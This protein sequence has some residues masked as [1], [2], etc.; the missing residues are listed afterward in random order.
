MNSRMRLAPWLMIVATVIG[1]GVASGA[2]GVDNWCNNPV[3]TPKPTPRPTPAPPCEPKECDKCKRSPCYVG[4]G[5][6]ETKADDLIVKTTGFPLQ[7]GRSYQ[8]SLAIDGP[9]GFGWSSS[10][11]VRIFYAVYLFAAPSTYQKEADIVM[12]DGAR[13]SFK[14]TG[15]GVFTPPMGRYDTLIR[16]ADQSFDMILQRSQSVLHFDPTGNL[17]SMTDDYGNVL[18]WV[19]DGNGRLQR[20][21]DAGGSGRYFDVFWG[22]DGRLSSVRDSSGRQI[23]YLYNASGALSSATDAASR[24][25]TYSYVQGRFSPLLSR[26]SDPWGRV[27]T[28]ITYD[29]GD[30]VRTYT[31]AGETYTYTYAYLGNSAVTAKTDSQGN[32]FIYPFNGVGLVS[33][34]TPPSGGGGPTHTDYYP[35]G[36]VQQFIDAVGVKS[37]NTYTANGSPLTVTKDYQGPSSVRYDYAYDPHFPAKPISI[38]PKKPTTGQVDPNWQAWRYDY[39]QAGD[40]APGALHHV[41]RV[42]DDGTTLDTMAT[43]EYDSQ[44]RITHQTGPTGGMTDYAYD[45]AGNL[46]TVTA[47]ANN[48]LGIRPVTTSGYDSLGRATSLTD[49]MSHS[50]TYAFDT[51]D[52]VISLTLPKPSAISSLTFTT[53]YAYDNYDSPSLLLFIH[54]TDPNAR[55]RKQGYDQYGQLVRSIDSQGN[56]TAYAHTRGVLTSMTDSNGNISNYAYDSGRRMTSTIF[57][58]N[59]IESYSYTGDNLL[60]QKTDRKN[61]TITYSYDHFKR[62][63]SKGY[64]NSTS[65][66]C[67]YQGQK[68]TQIVDT[69]VSPSETHT[70]TYDT[71]YRLESETQATRG[72]ISRQYNVDDTVASYSVQS[73]PTATYGYYPD[74]SLDT[75]GWTPVS[76]NFKYAYTPTGQYQTILFPSGQTRNL[77]YDD[78]GRLTQLANLAS[79]GANLATYGYGYDLNQGTGAFDMLGQRVSMTATV[80]SQGLSNSLFKYE[81]DS[82][83]ELKKVTYPAAAPYSGEVHSWTYDAIGNRQTNTVNGSTQTYIYQKIGA[84]PSN[85]Q[86]LLSDG[87]NSYTYDANGSTAA[88]T[89]L[90]F[91]WNADNRLTGISGA[92]PAIYGY[93]YQGRRASKIVGLATTYLYDGLNLVQEQGAAPADYLIGP[94]IDE[95]LAISR[96]GQVY[97]YATDSLGSVAAIADSSG[98][99]QNTYLYDAWGQVKSQT[100]TLSNPFTYTA[101]EAGEI[102]INF[103]RARYYSPGIGRFLQEDPVR[104]AAGPSWFTYVLNRPARF[105]DPAGL[106]A[107]DQETYLKCVNE[108]EEQFAADRRACNSTYDNCTPG[109][110]P[111]Y[112]REGNYPSPLQYLAQISCEVNCQISLLRCMAGA[113]TTHASTRLV[114]E[115]AYRFNRRRDGPA[116]PPES[117]T[118]IQ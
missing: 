9:L 5:T 32:R 68:L 42:H 67:T 64:P 51:L 69:S 36:S 48:D 85:W 63:A 60:S 2:F 90:A 8:S 112:C 97:Y 21:Q 53:T 25:T 50:T 92:V 84:N 4:S 116:F 16:N 12:P 62:L 89:G 114:C 76:G 91:V 10:L 29:T 61:Q 65:F 57:P 30:R 35:D 56:T 93:D 115:V 26:I 102:A 103:Y 77:S 43:Y 46:T 47:P 108:T 37:F 31:E 110:R 34:T 75:I 72:T 88:K 80:P 78:Q 74:G 14:D 44:G 20:V 23:Q 58:D 107:I 105:R 27:I 11:V 94:G 104:S 17:A 98:A 101:R 3:P 28:D 83:Y 87:S 82:L 59:A 95:P 33:D 54:V 66:T 106:S 117:M 19:Y 70:L 38:T 79:G 39:Y 49:P 86:R 100:G 24:T 18:Q 118:G 13:Y 45:G 7:T 40:P 1:L 52:R 55:I 99:V 73:G 22:A 41:F 111:P 71:A 109:C 15:T 113:Q 81:Y 6:Y 96:G